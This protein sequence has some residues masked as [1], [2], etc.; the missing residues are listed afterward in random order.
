M[1]FEECQCDG[2]IPHAGHRTY[3]WIKGQIIADP[4]FDEMLTPSVIPRREMFTRV[5]VTSEQLAREATNRK[6]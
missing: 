1:F 3:R 2:P 6:K 4:D 5:H